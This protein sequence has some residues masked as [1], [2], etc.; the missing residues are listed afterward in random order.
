MKM[1]KAT[2]PTYLAGK[3]PIESLE[4]C[5]I[6]AS[7]PNCTF[8]V[9]LRFHVLGRWHLYGKFIIIFDVLFSSLRTK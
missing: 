3:C 1:K 9:V 5:P 8:G 4:S 7:C 2:G 6:L